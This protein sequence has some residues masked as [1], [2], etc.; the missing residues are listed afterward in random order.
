MASSF[1]VF[2]MLHEGDSYWSFK[3]NKEGDLIPDYGADYNKTVNKSSTKSF[4]ITTWGKQGSISDYM[5]ESNKENEPSY[6]LLMG[7]KVAQ[8]GGYEA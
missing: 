7:L 1:G 4:F 2:Q 3:E 5:I 6:T 8:I